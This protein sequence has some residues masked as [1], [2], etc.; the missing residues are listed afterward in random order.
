[1]SSPIRLAEVGTIIGDPARATMLCALLDGR[2]HSA[3]DLALAAGVSPQTASWHLAKLADGRLISAERQGRNRYFRLASTLVAQALETMM[4]FAESQPS[5]ARVLS[6]REKA[7]RHARTCYDHLAGK[8]GVALTEALTREKLI[9]LSAEGGLVTSHGAKLLSDFGV[10]LPALRQ[11]K[12]PLCR[13]CLDWSEQ[14]P[15]L[16]GA[17]G[18][19]LTSRCFDLGWVR[20]LPDTRAVAITPAGARGFTEQ[21]GSALAI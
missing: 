8:L 19:A 20:R 16:A 18:A 9:E 6:E 1:M 14:K 17:I 3:T 21:F 7:L 12:R 10:D 15:H 11:S 5:R 2:R 4:A 13:S